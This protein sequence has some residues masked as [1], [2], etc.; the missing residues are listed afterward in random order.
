MKS[1]FKTYTI[2][3]IALS[4]T[5]AFYSCGNKSEKT[6]EP[7][8][9]QPL[10]VSTNADG[11]YKSEKYNLMFTPPED[12]VMFNDSQM[13]TQGEG[14]ADFTYEMIAEHVTGFPHV[15]VV[16][17]KTAHKTLEEYTN[18]L[19]ANFMGEGN[20]GFLVEDNEGMEIAGESYSCFT[21]FSGDTIIEK[22]CVRQVND[23]FLCIIAI[24]ENGKNTGDE[25]WSS[26]SDIK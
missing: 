7:K 17:E 11:I 12:Y 23:E 19:K 5:A 3:I 4:L 20:E 16:S 13:T 8:Q 9:E 21:V 10:E 22:F 15:M 24:T 14:I 26:F 18:Y 6:P 1:V 2:A 25:I